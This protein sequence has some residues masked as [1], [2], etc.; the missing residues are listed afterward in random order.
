M[1]RREAEDTRRT[2]K[3]L[4]DQ[5]AYADIK[6]AREKLQRAIDSNKDINFDAEKVIGWMKLIEKE[7]RPRTR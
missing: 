2:R 1:I 4:P 6:P 5:R 7:T 3:A